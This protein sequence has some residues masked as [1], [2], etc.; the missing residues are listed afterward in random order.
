MSIERASSAGFR[1]VSWT[2]WALWAALLLCL[3]GAGWLAP[4]RASEPAIVVPSPAVDVPADAANGGV[5]TAVLA[6]GCFWG[7]QAVFQ[8]VKGVTR[9]VSGYAGGAKET[10]VYQIVGSGQTGH[11]E[12]VQVTYDP[13]QI[14]Y[15]K[16]LQIYFSVA[17]DPTQLDRQGPDFGPQYRSA[18]FYLDEAQKNVA[19]AYIAQLNKAG[20]FKHP[21]VTQVNRLPAFYPAEDYHQDYASLHPSSPYIAFN[22]LPKVENLRRIFPDLYREK[23]VLVFAAN[24][25]N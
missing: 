15:G 10:A 24:Q 23:P 22:D 3:A 12:S 20:V 2:G 7:V 14:S 9:A 21:I 11:A 8:H 25:T 13:R 17:H 4:I 1:K 5:Q 16:I 6:G 18:I 19:E